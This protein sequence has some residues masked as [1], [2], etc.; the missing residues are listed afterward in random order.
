MIQDNVSILRH[1]IESQLPRLFPHKEM[2]IGSRDE[3]MGIFGGYYSAYHPP[4][5]VETSGPGAGGLLSTMGIKEWVPEGHLGGS[6][7]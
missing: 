5:C 2:L 6:G 4:L 3:D 1:L 7:C